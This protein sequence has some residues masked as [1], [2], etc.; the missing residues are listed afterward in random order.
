MHN[1]NAN[2][3]QTTNSTYFSLLCADAQC[4]SASNGTKNV[5]IGLGT[6]QL[7]SKM[8]STQV[9]QSQVPGARWLVNLRRGR[10]AQSGQAPGGRNS[11]AKREIERA[12]SDHTSKSTERIEVILGSPERSW[13]GAAA[14]ITEKRSKFDSQKLWAKVWLAIV[15]TCL[16]STSTQRTEVIQDFNTRLK[17]ELKFKT[18]LSHIS[19]LS[20][21]PQRRNAYLLLGY[22]FFWDNVFINNMRNLYHA[23]CL[24][25]STT[26]TEQETDGITIRIRNRIGAGGGTSKPRCSFEFLKL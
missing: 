12:K 25:L 22:S 24:M 14:G 20:C 15:K 13:Q 1:L 3:V 18:F 21:Q 5:E 19:R 8:P 23:L 7:L 4:N 9:P 2:N 6:R 26:L 10:T 16:N 11:P 17:V